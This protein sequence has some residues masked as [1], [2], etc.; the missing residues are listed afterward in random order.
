MNTTIAR[1]VVRDGLAACLPDA[2]TPPCDN[3]S[4]A[5]TSTPNSER[6]ERERRIQAQAELEGYVCGT[7][8]HV[9]RCEQIDQG[10]VPTS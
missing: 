9:R 1:P 6:R 5:N 7:R 3:E 2:V 8:G 4:M 10:I